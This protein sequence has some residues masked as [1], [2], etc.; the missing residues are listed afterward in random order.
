MP[1]KLIPGGGGKK[2]IKNSV[3]KKKTKM[4]Q[5]SLTVTAKDMLS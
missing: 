2:L 4:K 3:S 1:I 5:F